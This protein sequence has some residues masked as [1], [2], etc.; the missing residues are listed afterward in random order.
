MTRR[1]ST[2]PRST[3]AGRAGVG[4][5]RDSPA[6]HGKGTDRY[7]KAAQINRLGAPAWSSTEI[8][9]AVQIGG[10]S[11]AAADQRWS[12]NVTVICAGAAPDRLCASGAMANSPQVMGTER[13]ILAAPRLDLTPSGGTGQDVSPPGL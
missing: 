2:E 4:A 12:R 6:G 8:T 7:A 10:Y 13:P 11:H 3:T 9:L 1:S 5:N